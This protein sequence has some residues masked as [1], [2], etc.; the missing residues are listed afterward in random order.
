MYPQWRGS[1]V[2]CLL[3]DV[4]PQWRV[5]SV[6]CLLSHMC[7]Q[8]HVS[9]VTCLLSDVFRQW[10]VSSVTYLLGVVSLQWHVSSVSCHLSIS[11]LTVSTLWLPFPCF[12]GPSM[13]LHSDYKLSGALYDISWCLLCRLYLS[14]WFSLFLHF[15][16]Y[17][18]LW[19][20]VAIFPHSSWQLLFSSPGVSSRSMFQ[21]R[22][23]YISVC[24][25]Y[26][27]GFKNTTAC[28]LKA[29]FLNDVSNQLRVSSMTCLLRDVSPQWHFSSVTCLLNDAPP[30]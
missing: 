24:T 25:Y 21:L 9:S 26:V 28:L 12:L 14:H 19:C 1:S 22:I 7:P 16:F 30:P 5:S 20:S 11:F 18:S 2:T 3:S 29:C 4:S 13:V 17:L 10:R 6:T 27:S 8:S 15:V 23:Y